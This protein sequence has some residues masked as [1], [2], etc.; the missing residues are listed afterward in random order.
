M[1]KRA[2]RVKDALDIVGNMIFE[3]NAKYGMSDARVG[4]V[5]RGAF[6][7]MI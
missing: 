3:T 1:N 4:Y 5:K 6:V 2:I 7:V